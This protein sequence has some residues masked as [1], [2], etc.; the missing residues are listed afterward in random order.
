[1]QKEYAIDKK[2]RAYENRIR[3]LKTEERELRVQGDIERANQLR[4]KCRRLTKDYQI[5]SI[6]NN[7]AYYPYRCVIDRAENDANNLIEQ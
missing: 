4:K 2:Q 6:E 1:M 7:R 5:Y 3:Q